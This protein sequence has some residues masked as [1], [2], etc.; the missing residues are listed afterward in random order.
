MQTYWTIETRKHYSIYVYYII[1][2]EYLCEYHVYW[3]KHT[4]INLISISFIFRVKFDLDK[5][6]LSKDKFPLRMLREI[7]KRVKSYF[8]FESKQIPN[9]FN[10]QFWPQI[11]PVVG[12]AYCL[13]ISKLVYNWENEVFFFSSNMLHVAQC[14]RI[15]LSFQSH[16]PNGCKIIINISRLRLSLREAF[17]PKIQ[18]INYL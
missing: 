8:L 4:K 3:E 5:N 11:L 1:L 12:L 9:D 16:Q 7:K 10:G 17:K 18:W 14:G 2:Y 13:G 15:S 6:K